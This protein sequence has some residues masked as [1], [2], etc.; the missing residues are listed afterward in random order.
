MCE[1]GEEVEAQLSISSRTLASSKG[2]PDGRESLSQK[3][4]LKTQQ[5][6]SLP[7]CPSDCGPSSVQQRSRR[8]R[9]TH[10]PKKALYGNVVTPM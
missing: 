6:S 8:E 2:C 10:P 1:G 5:N 7:T 9:G 3:V 4:T